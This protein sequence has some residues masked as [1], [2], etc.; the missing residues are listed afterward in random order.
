[1]K[2]VALDKAEHKLAFGEPKARTA[3]PFKR[4]LA[5]FAIAASAVVVAFIFPLKQVYSQSEKE[6]ANLL[7]GNG[8][9]IAFTPPTS[10]ASTFDI[11]NA[12]D[13][14]K[15]TGTGPD[16]KTA[17]NA[18]KIYG[19]KFCDV[20]IADGKIIVENYVANG[21]KFEDELALSNLK[22]KYMKNLQIVYIKDKNIVYLR[23]DY[24]IYSV[25]FDVKGDKCHIVGEGYAIPRLVSS[26]FVKSSDNSTIVFT[27][28]KSMIIFKVGEWPPAL[29]N[30]DGSEFFTHE[31]A[32]Y[33]DAAKKINVASTPT[34]LF[35][36][37]GEQIFIIKYDDRLGPGPA[38][39][40]P[41]LDKY[42][43]EGRETVRIRD[44]SMPGQ[45][46][47]LDPKNGTLGLFNEP[48]EVGMIR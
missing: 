20:R 30:H 43:Y 40:N 37:S 46:M 32:V 42:L 35:V 47:V 2:R 33:E 38:L 24:G 19:E 44:P 29:F 11:T 18:P 4:A 9:T 22:I 8:K 16:V 27:E 34:T 15:V 13:P 26:T 23:G 7:S 25:T 6:V 31:G 45:Y 14:P 39:E 21:N 1:M 10:G 17:T 28:E 36:K 41:I 3:S 48:T 12:G 5:K